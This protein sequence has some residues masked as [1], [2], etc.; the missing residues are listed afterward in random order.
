[1][2]TPTRPIAQPARASSPH[3]MQGAAASSPVVS[4]AAFVLPDKLLL[5]YT[6]TRRQT[7]CH[8]TTA[9]R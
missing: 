1:M 5:S 9:T 3:E 8:C 6:T 2:P 7:A 4:G